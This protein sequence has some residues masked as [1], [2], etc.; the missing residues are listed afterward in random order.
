MDKKI[1]DLYSDYLI[2]SF[3][4]I[5]ATGLSAALDGQVSHDAVTRLLSGDELD[6][7]QLWLLVKPMVRR[8][9]RNEGVIVFDDT[10]EEKPYTKESELIC[11]HHDHTKNRSVKGINLLNCL[12]KTD[13]VS[14]PLG[15]DLV[16]KPIEFCDIKTKKRKRKSTTSKNELLRARL[17]VCQRNQIKYRY[18]LT[19]SWF[20]SKENMG[21]IRHDLDKHFIM[22]LKTNRTVALTEEDKKQGGFTR[23]DQ[24]E[25]QEHTPVQAWIK[26]L[27]F[28]VLLHRQL[29]TNKDGSTG[30]LYLACS[31]LT[32][33]AAGIEAIYQKRWS[34]EVFHKTLK[35]NVGLAKSPTQCIRT[36]SNHVFMAIYAAFQLE[37]L[38]LT[39]KM[40][41][42]A[43]RSK[44]YIGA[45][46]QALKELAKLRGQSA[47]A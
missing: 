8:Y 36:Q 4:Y 2:S 29:F 22:S 19:D 11:W 18:V 35:S 31:D 43:L 10:I 47:S 24:L 46:Q 9:E 12:Y 39:H 25:W 40:N 17:A 15:F 30:T 23:I 16:K 3:S 6:S 32:C 42:F 26:G 34:V 5:T 1:L 20:A 44:L 27:D 45:L 28:P 41:H 7:K 38:H 21:F 13:E 37:Y 14:F 33:D